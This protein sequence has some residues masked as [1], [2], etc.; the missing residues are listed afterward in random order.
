MLVTIGEEMR[1]SVVAPER[2]E[3]ARRRE[4]IQA[5]RKTA[6]ERGWEILDF[7]RPVQLRR[8]V[9]LEP[10]TATLAAVAVGAG[11]AA[12]TVVALSLRRSRR[13]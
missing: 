6:H 1:D 5:L 10:R 3:S 13:T 9:P 12:A 2:L 4:T 7:V 8:R 11:V